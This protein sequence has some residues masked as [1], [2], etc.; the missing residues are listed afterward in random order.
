MKKVSTI[1]LFPS[2]IK[3]VPIIFHCTF[4]VSS[5]SMVSLFQG[6]H[7]FQ[8]SQGREFFQLD[9][10]FTYLIKLFRVLWIILLRALRHYFFTQTWKRLT[11]QFSQFSAFIKLLSAHLGMLIWSI[12]LFEE[13]LSLLFV[14]SWLRIR[15]WSDNPATMWKDFIRFI[16]EDQIHLYF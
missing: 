8:F 6:G 15:W 1:T 16:V 9:L 2:M 14:I 5:K 3:G 13:K 12:A 10:F 11:V 4:E 7:I